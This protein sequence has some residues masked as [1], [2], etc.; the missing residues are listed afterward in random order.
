MHVNVILLNSMHL[1][2]ERLGTF[3]SV[4]GDN[5]RLAARSCGIRSPV[6]RW[7]Q[8]IIIHTSELIPAASQYVILD[9]G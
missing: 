8:V 1:S 5:L 4:V 3:D 2:S 9:A 7:S 6:S